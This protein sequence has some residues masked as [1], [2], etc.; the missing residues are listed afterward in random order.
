LGENVIGLSDQ[1]HIASLHRYP[2]KS[3][4]G[5][6]VDSL[7]I[8]EEGAV[9]DRQLA[10]LDTATGRI[11]S[12]KQARLWRALLQCTASK[13]DTGVHIRFPDNTQIATDH[14]DI[15]HRLSDLLSRAVR[16]VDHRSEGAAVERADPD[17]AL[18]RGL[19]A[20]VDAPIM[21]LGAAT[22]GD[23][24]VDL[25][26]L[27]I[28]TTATLHHIGVETMRYRPNVVIQT[29]HEFPPYAENDWVGSILKLGDTRTRVL[30]RTPRCVIPTLEHGALSRAPQAL[31][32]P[33]A[34]NRVQAFDFGE[35]P[36]V[37]VYL[38]VQTGGT[39]R[40]GDAVIVESPVMPT[41]PKRSLPK[42][43]SK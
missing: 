11:A 1:A 43:S 15:D 24:F 33:A 31:R 42:P 23:S 19:D 18:E 20:E 17:Q 38:A 34:Q 41:V 39:L 40:T 22:P 4:L 35:L 30:G 13:D 2:V 26:P 28:I 9:G 29:P 3:M 8:T 10:L 16:L 36:C 37:G 7:Q 25:A 6:T 21:E 14:P 32:T 5:E 27:H 12:A